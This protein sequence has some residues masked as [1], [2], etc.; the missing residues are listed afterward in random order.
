LARIAVEESL[1]NVKEALENNGHE[2]VRMEA[3]NMDNCQCCII[4]GQDKDVM[5]VENAETQ[6]SVINADGLTA[7][8]IVKQVNQ[9]T[10][11]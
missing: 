1:N 7:E 9:R 3:N 5:G 6:A 8:E 10:A 11:Q 2:V 4:S